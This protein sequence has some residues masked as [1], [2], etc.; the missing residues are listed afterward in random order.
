MLPASESQALGA[1]AARLPELVRPPPRPCHPS[2]VQSVRRGEHGGA[3]GRGSHCQL[4]RESAGSL[5]PRTDSRWI[6]PTS[7]VPVPFFLFQLAPSQGR[8]AWELRVLLA[9]GLPAASA[10]AGEA[11]LHSAR[12]LSSLSHLPSRP[13][14]ASRHSRTCTL[15]LSR[16][17]SLS[18][19][20]SR[21]R[22]GLPWC[23]NSQSLPTWMGPRLCII[24]AE[25]TSQGQG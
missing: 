11:G 3:G 14:P 19:P 23:W 16:L 15:R 4:Q 24:L 13:C 20:E 25:G 12:Q 5:G 1:A 7:A 2:W 22:P 9:W 8:G 21:C 17:P 6:G 10:R 18:S